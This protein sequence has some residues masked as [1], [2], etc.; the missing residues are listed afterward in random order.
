VGRKGLVAIL[1]RKIAHRGFAL[2][3]PQAHAAGI[4]A[5]LRK[6]AYKIA[7]GNFSG[8][9]PRSYT[10]RLQ[11]KAWLVVFLSPLR[12]YKNTLGIAGQSLRPMQT[13][14]LARERQKGAHIF[15]TC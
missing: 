10:E 9:L 3:I 8:L 5:V 15:L 1:L 6:Y 2:Q 7:A 4:A 13:G 12:G 11:W 14:F